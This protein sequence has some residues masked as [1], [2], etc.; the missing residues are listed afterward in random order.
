M[1]GF[2]SR[3]G[4]FQE[5]VFGP[6]AEILC[7]LTCTE[8]IAP[9]AIGYTDGHFT[10]LEHTNGIP[11]TGVTAHD[12]TPGIG[13]DIKVNQLSIAFPG[14]APTIIG[15]GPDNQW[16]DVNNNWASAMDLA[17]N[18]YSLTS[19][20]QISPLVHLL[21]LFTN[22]TH[23]GGWADQT[24]Y[25][26]QPSIWFHPDTGDQWI[27][28]GTSTV[29]MIGP[30]DVTAFNLTQSTTHPWV[31]SGYRNFGLRHP[32][33]H[34]DGG[35][36]ATAGPGTSIIYY[37]G[38]L[39]THW[40][41]HPNRPIEIAHIYSNG[42]VLVK[43]LFGVGEYAVTAAGITRV[44]NFTCDIG[45]SFGPAQVAPNGGSHVR[46]GEDPDNPGIFSACRTPIGPPP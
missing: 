10:A 30:A 11:T 38:P 24:A 45:N 18:K 33:A 29:S 39:G 17:G 44:G 1:V 21:G 28:N 8:V 3:T 46:Y 19:L 37:H 9:F 43:Q 31:G 4:I 12:P 20:N 41:Q 6:E 5:V 2:G 14:G 13:T 40:N 22:G 26:K 32:T 34:P 15:L 27:F 25:G 35:F 16:A 23:N 36:W 7:D 42:N